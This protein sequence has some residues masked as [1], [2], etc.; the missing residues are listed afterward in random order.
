MLTPP[1]CMKLSCLELT[2]CGL[3][4]PRNKSNIGFDCAPHTARLPYTA[5]CLACNIMLHNTM[6][7]LLTKRH[8][9]Q[10][11]DVLALQLALLVTKHGDSR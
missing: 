2:P 7:Q 5:F 11:I 10:H 8:S 4:V 1:T 9:H 3:Q 6:L